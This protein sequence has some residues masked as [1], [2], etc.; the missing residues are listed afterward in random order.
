[1]T[2]IKDFDYVDV[3]ALRLRLRNMTDEDLIKCGKAARSLIENRLKRQ[4]DEPWK[5]QLEMAREEWKRRH[6]KTKD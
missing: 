2:E 4:S 3:D 5:T 6:P 1:M